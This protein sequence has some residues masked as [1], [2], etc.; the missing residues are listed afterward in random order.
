MDNWLGLTIST[1]IK[2][3]IDYIG[4]GMQVDQVGLG[5]SKTILNGMVSNSIKIH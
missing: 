2:P 3:I 4:E 5:S 1:I